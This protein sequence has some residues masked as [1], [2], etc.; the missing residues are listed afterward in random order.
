MGPVALVRVD[1]DKRVVLL[2]GDINAVQRGVH[3]EPEVVV[4]AHGWD[5][6]HRP[7]KVASRSPTG[8]WRHSRRGRTPTRCCRRWPCTGCRWRCRPR[9]RRAV[10]VAREV[11]DGAAAGVVRRVAGVRVESRPPVQGAVHCHVHRV[12]GQVDVD[13][14]GCCADVDGGRPGAWTGGEIGGVTG[15]AVDHRNV[16]GPSSAV[17]EVAERRDIHGVVVRVGENPDRP[18]TDGHDRRR[19]R[20]ACVVHCVACSTVEDRYAAPVG[21]VHACRCARR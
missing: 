10:W 2:V 9:P 15:R 11:A 3:G 12:V 19:L 18:R 7:G 1:H 16:C 17:A 5:R 13:G 14:N 4:E 6:G 20:A 8:R 21:H